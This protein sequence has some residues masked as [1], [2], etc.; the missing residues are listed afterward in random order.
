MPPGPRRIGLALFLSSLLQAGCREEARPAPVATPGPRA[1]GVLRFALTEPGGLDPARSEDTYQGLVI[2]QIFEGLVDLDSNLNVVPAL[3]KSWIVDSDGLGYHFLIRENAR[4][5]NGRPVAA[6]DVAW[7][8]LRAAKLP[9]TVAREHLAHIAG[10]HDVMAGKAPTISGVRVDGPRAVT[11]TLAEPY[12]PFLNTLA[13][14]QMRI[15][16]RESV[17]AAGADFD[18]QP[19]GSGPFELQAWRPGDRI[20]LKA[21]ERHWKGRPY[22]DS[23]E[24]DVAPGHD[25]GAFESFLKGDLDLA[26][27]GRAEQQRLPPG[28]PVVQRLEMAVTFLGLNLAEAPFDDPRVRRAAALSVDR[29]AIVAASGR[30]AVATRGSVPLGMVGGPSHALAPDRDVDQARRVLAEAG[31]PGGRGLAMAHVWT[32]AMS[33]QTRATIQALAGN[34]EDVGIP[35]RQHAV[36]WRSLV[37]T[38]DAGKAPAYLMT[39]VADTPDRDS[40]LGVL[41]HS[42]GS[43]NYLHYSDGEVDRLLAAASRQMDP[44]ERIRLY[45]EV[46]KRVGAA[47]VLIPLYSEETTFALRRGLKGVAV[48]PMGQINLAH[49][50]WES[51]R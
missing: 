40:F 32:N 12:A 13:T 19:V 7:S 6:E 15:V 34:L 26:S 17:E 27:F 33:P 3:A 37:E 14:P 2:A 35:V 38:V 43:S 48:D 5:Q 30:V 50:Y 29:E 8:F 22:L 11:L 16:P 28:T 41:F 20:I 18:H 24:I 44:M 42:R 51:G 4:F 23:I 21:N 49:A 45:D 47:D 31:H 39:W 25:D 46:E 9:V 36:S 1:G 10:A